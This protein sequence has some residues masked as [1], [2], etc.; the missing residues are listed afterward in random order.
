MNTGRVVYNNLYTKTKLE[1]IICDTPAKSYILY[2]KRSLLD[3][4]NLNSPLKTREDFIAHCDVDFHSGL[5]TLVDIPNFDL[6]NDVPFDCVVLYMYRYSEKVIDNL[7][8]WSKT[9]QFSSSQ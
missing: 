7:E 5:T 2:V 6:V 4:P 1:A 8:R 3:F 9:A